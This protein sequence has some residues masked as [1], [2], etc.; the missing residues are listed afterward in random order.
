MNIR[1]KGSRSVTE[2][3]R[4]VAA[5]VRRLRTEQ[6]MTLSELGLQLGISHQQLQK[7]ET[8][9]NR[10]SAG[11]LFETAKT[12]GVTPNELFE[13]NV[14]NKLKKQP[15]PREVER[16]IMDARKAI[17]KA[18]NYIE[19][20]EY[21]AEQQKSAGRTLKTQTGGPSPSLAAQAASFSDE[22]E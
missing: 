4:V 1:E 20:V 12:L 14:G 6:K 3:D 18:I 8:G 13:G 15:V 16:A 11:M 2:I 7:Y 9:A 21:E 19:E 17:A 22:E 5:N 10:F